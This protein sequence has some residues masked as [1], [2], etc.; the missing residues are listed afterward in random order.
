M[1]NCVLF[2]IFLFISC[3]E[4]V[5]WNVELKN[6]TFEFQVLSNEETA[7]IKYLFMK[8]LDN[9]SITY[10]FLC[11]K[12]ENTFYDEVIS[13]KYFAVCY[14][15]VAKTVNKD[16]KFYAQ[17]YYADEIVLS[18][19]CEN[20]R[21]IE[22][23][24]IN[25]YFREVRCESGNIRIDVDLSN[26]FFLLYKISAFS[27]K[28]GGKNKSYDYFAG[29]S[30]YFYGVDCEQSKLTANLS[31]S[32]KNYCDKNF[33]LEHGIKLTTTRFDNLDISGLIK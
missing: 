18:A 30:Y 17:A 27:V 19:D 6:C 3:S 32:V 28:N 11:E 12:A 15:L 1:K 25:I 26:D 4:T 9:S 33:L 29:S 8:N 7:E 21:N 14:F 10:N 13:G 16:A 31:Y 2:F 20:K 24:V 23:T 5:I 22:P